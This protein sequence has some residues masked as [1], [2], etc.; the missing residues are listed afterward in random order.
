MLFAT[1]NFRISFALIS[2][3]ILEDGNGHI[4]ST[5][6]NL[7]K[8]KGGSRT[9]RK[10]LTAAAD[11]EQPGNGTILFLVVTYSIIIDKLLYPVC[12]HHEAARYLISDIPYVYLFNFAI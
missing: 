7:A 12:S 6:K 1:D 3:D 10:C 11:F 2:G 9:L 4:W 8:M 5:E